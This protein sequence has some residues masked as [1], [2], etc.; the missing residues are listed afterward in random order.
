M[1]RQSST[2]ENANPQSQQK[3]H[4]CR[5]FGTTTEVDEK[6]EGCKVWLWIFGEDCYD[7]PGQMFGRSDC[8][9]LNIAV[10]F[11]KTVVLKLQVFV[12]Q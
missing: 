6:C 11:V 3:P 1:F 12:F 2:S 7:G 9:C 10:G 5:S 8:D 4:F